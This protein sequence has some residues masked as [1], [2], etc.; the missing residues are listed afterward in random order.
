M[1]NGYVR[2]N[3][4]VLRTMQLPPDSTVMLRIVD[5]DENEI[6]YRDVRETPYVYCLAL[7]QYED[8]DGNVYKDVAILDVTNNEIVY[9][10]SFVVRLQR[11]PVCG[12]YMAPTGDCSSPEDIHYVCKCGA[13]KLAFG[14]EILV[15]E[16]HPGR[17][18]Y[19]FGY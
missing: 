10:G 4:V 18:Q 14:T 13:E 16:D 17:S 2:R 5:E 12:K 11:C 7:I 1:S 9:D 6:H 19:S 3:E 15:H 8:N